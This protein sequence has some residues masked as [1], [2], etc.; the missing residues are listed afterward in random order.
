[1]LYSMTGYGE[2][3]RQADGLAVAV[4][5]RTINSRYF[6]LSYRATDGYASLEPRVEAAVRQQVRR[7][8]VQ[9]QV[10]VDRPHAPGDYRLNVELLESFRQKLTDL[11]AN[12]D[13]VRLADRAARQVAQSVHSQQAIVGGG[14]E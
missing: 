3:R 1:M 7:G 14:D 2:A 9:V 6:K 10:R 11:A 4:E 13:D 12:W 5:V 8:T